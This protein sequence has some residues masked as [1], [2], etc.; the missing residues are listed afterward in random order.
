VE[1]RRVRHGDIPQLMRFI[2]DYHISSNLSDI[3]F[4]KKSMTKII[5]YYRQ[6]RDSVALIAVKDGRI[7]GLLFGSIEPFFFNQKR[8]YATDLMFFAKAGGVQL[9]RHFVDWAW[10]M[11]ASRVMMGVS[12]GDDRADQLFDVLG[13]EQ[14]GGMYVLRQESS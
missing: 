11:G 14:T 13:M 9:W 1:V 3:P 7:T 8:S 5:D 6:A 2:Q 12:S 4:D 10:S